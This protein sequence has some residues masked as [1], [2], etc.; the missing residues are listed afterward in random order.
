MKPL[1][2]VILASASPRR[3]E[4]LSLLLPAFEV[5]VPRVDETPQPGEAAGDYAERLAAEKAVEVAREA[6]AGAIIV[7]ADTVVVLDG[8]ILGKPRDAADA[9]RMLA[10][11]S[12]RSHEVITGVCVRTA[13]EGTG[14]RFRT[15][16]E[17]RFRALDEEEI[18]EYVESGEPMDKAGA[19]AIQSGA[20]HMVK[21]I[22]G[23]YTNVVGLPLCEVREAFRRLLNR[24]AP[25]R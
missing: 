14:E 10:A 11:L 20:A 21:E 5:R 18:A 25:G 2:P 16:T 23:S 24:P 3:K 4:L 9:H 19:Y 12:G 13:E 22:R 6:P 15:V 17:V 7:A 8:R 1:R